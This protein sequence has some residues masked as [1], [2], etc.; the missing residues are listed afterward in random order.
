MEQSYLLALLYSK[1]AVSF[2][3]PFNFPLY[4]AARAGFSHYAVDY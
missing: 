3:Y 2:I 4:C 1:M